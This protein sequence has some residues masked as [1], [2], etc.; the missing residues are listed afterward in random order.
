MLC[1]P[2]GLVNDLLLLAGAR[3]GGTMIGRLRSCSNER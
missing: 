1:L 2:R 3:C